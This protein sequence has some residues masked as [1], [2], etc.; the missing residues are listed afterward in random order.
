VRQAIVIVDR[1]EQ[2]IRDWIW[3]E[4][5]ADH[6][7]SPLFPDAWIYHE[8]LLLHPYALVSFLWWTRPYTVIENNPSLTSGAFVQVVLVVS[9]TFNDWAI[10]PA[11]R[12]SLDFL[13]V[14]LFCFDLI[15]FETRFL[16]VAQGYPGKS[17]CRPVCLQTQKD[18]PASASQ[19]LE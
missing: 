17:L 18:W 11:L 12:I 9:L 19:V 5:V 1:T 2:G 13:S 16:R 15:W 8:Q 6:A 4:G 7:V 10:S 14:C 3:V